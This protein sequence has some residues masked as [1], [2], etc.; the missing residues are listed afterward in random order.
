MTRGKITADIIEVSKELH[1]KNLLAATD[2]NISSRLDDG[3]VLITPS[4]H[5]KS[6]IKPEQMALVDADGSVLDGNPSSELLMH[7]KVYELCPQAKFVIHAH[8]PTAVAWSIARPELKELPAECFSEVILALGSIPFVPY[9][10]PGTKD[11]A[12]NL[13]P[14]LPDYRVMILSRHGGL[15]WGED[16]QEALNGIERLEHSCEMLWK[17]QTLGGINPLPEEELKFL[18]NK[19]KEIGPRTL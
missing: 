18:R 13:I 3:K 9:A 8:P 1:R 14:F 5:S 17:A 19:R 12:V 6:R 7:L 11:M 10:R 4:G 16:L 2:G 15:S